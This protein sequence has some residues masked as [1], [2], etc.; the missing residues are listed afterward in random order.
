MAL[1]DFESA[2]NIAFSIDEYEIPMLSVDLSKDVEIEQIRANQ[3]KAIGY[4]VTE[5][6]FGGT[7]TFPGNGYISEI[8]DLISGGEIDAVHLEDLF[9]NDEGIPTDGANVGIFH[10]NENKQTTYEDVMVISDGYET[11]TGEVSGVTFEVIAGDRNRENVD[12]DQ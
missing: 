1:E 4:S 6:D 12:G 7:V 3:L 8:E 10:E 2:A 11:E 9:T 5:I